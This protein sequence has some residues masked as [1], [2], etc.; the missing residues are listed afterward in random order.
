M[1]AQI[2]LLQSKHHHK[3]DRLLMDV[4]NIPEKQY[5]I[6]ELVLDNFKNLKLPK[7]EKN[8]LSFKARERVRTFLDLEINWLESMAKELIDRVNRLKRKVIHLKADNIGSFVCLYALKF[9]KLNDGKEL[10][11]H[12]NDCPLKIFEKYV[13]RITQKLGDRIHCN[14]RKSSWLYP[15]QTLYSTNSVPHLKCA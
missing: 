11:L 3:V 9:F 6:N 12:L 10:V 13:A 1:D 5:P 8:I 2:Y 15:Y 4:S 14:I 7:Q